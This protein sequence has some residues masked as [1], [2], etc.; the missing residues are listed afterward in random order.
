M[1]EKQSIRVWGFR[2][3]VQQQRHGLMW[4]YRTGAATQQM[5]PTNARSS[6]NKS[7]KSLQTQQ[8][9]LAC[10]SAPAAAPLPA[11]T[12][13]MPR[14]LSPTAAACSLPQRSS[15]QEKA[16]RK[17]PTTLPQQ[18][19]VVSWWCPCDLHTS[20]EQAIY[21]EHATTVPILPLPF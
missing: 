9:L 12:S 20:A 18:Y 21:S 10:Y 15:R 16:E 14:F 3:G 4:Y 19:R 1:K 11:Q 7:S 6:P 13:M 8:G 5:N 2:G 17:V